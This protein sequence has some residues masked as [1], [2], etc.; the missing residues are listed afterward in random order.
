VQRYT[1]TEGM[2]LTGKN[3]GY[4]VLPAR[5]VDKVEGP[6]IEVAPGVRAPQRFRMR[7]VEAVQGARLDAEVHAR[8]TAEGEPECFGLRVTRTD[9]GRIDW[10]LLQRLPI[11]EWLRDGLTRSLGLRDP[12]TGRWLH[13]GDQSPSPRR[14]ELLE[15][16]RKSTVGRRAGGRKPL[17]SALLDEVA[18]IY[19]DGWSRDRRPIKALEAAFP[20]NARPTIQKWVAAARKAGVLTLPPPNKRGGQRPAV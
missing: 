4:V 12:E 11:D 20:N 3:T 15:Q 13:P 1:R 2:P 8:L 9:A 19:V 6:W 5:H 7:I 18:R 16:L 10:R 14:D 17:D